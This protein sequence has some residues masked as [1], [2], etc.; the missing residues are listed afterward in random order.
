MSAT[1]LKEPGCNPAATVR[2]PTSSTGATAEETR[3]HHGTPR[4]TTTV[5]ERPAS[6]ASGRAD[7]GL[8]AVRALRIFN[9][10][11]YRRSEDGR[12]KGSRGTLCAHRA[13]GEVPVMVGLGDEIAAGRG[14]LRGLR[15]P[16]GSRRSGRS[17]PRTW[18]ACWPKTNSTCASARHWRRPT[19]AEKLHRPHRRPARRAGRNTAAP[20][21]AGRGRT[22]GA[23]TRPNNRGRNRA[24]C[25]RVGVPSSL[26]RAITSTQSRSSS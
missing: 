24:V 20:A 5:G 14:H 26:P 22:A 19:Y 9:G 8:M 1:A 12:L 23:A 15:T 16:T 2:P 6:Q 7:F 10:G 13:P 11:H 25:S 21:R 3:P 4:T 18:R 17:R